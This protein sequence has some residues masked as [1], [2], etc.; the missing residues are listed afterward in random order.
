MDLSKPAGRWV[1][2]VLLGNG[3]TAGALVAIIMMVFVEMTGPRRR[4]LEVALD[5]QSLP[6]MEEFLRGFALKRGWDD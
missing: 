4:R 1:L 2:A 3:M 5:R 6:K